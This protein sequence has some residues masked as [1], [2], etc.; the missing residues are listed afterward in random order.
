VTTVDGN[1]AVVRFT[2]TGTH[3]GDLETPEGVLHPTHKHFKVDGVEVFT[4]DKEAKVTD[5]LSVEDLAGLMR[6]LKSKK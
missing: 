2:L 4:F 3:E 1:V 6:Q 5:L